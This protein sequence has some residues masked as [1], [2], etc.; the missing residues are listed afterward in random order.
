MVTRENDFEVSTTM[1]Y[2]TALKN[3]ESKGFN[4][5]F[6]RKDFKKKKC[7]ISVCGISRNGVTLTS[8]FKLCITPEV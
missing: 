8:F 4:A 3:P 7:F 6:D 1:K 5:H 2:K